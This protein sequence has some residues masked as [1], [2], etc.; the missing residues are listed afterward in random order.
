MAEEALERAIR[1][2]ATLAVAN[3]GEEE[4]MI[5][6]EAKARTNDPKGCNGKFSKRL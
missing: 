1:Q 3:G 6:K 4:S 2:H 5:I